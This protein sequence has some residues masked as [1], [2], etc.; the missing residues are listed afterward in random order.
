MLV[1]VWPE[2]AKLSGSC[3][4]SAT[5]NLFFRVV[6]IT[7]L[8]LLRRL[9]E[10]YPIAHVLLTGVAAAIEAVHGDEVR[11][12]A[13]GGLRMAHSDALVDDEDAVLLQRLDHLGVRAGGHSPKHHM[14]D[15]RS[16]AGNGQTHVLGCVFPWPRTMLDTWPSDGLPCS[17]R[18]PLRKVTQRPKMSPNTVQKRSASR[19]DYSRTNG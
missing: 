1:R 12:H 13:R 7:E 18:R 10:K 8:E 16:I 15:P 4:L 17:F 9:R 19:L 2:L 11:A 3:R 5:S 6:C 14:L